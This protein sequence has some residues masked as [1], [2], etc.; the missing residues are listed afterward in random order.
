MLMKYKA[1]PEGGWGWVVT[2][3]AFLTYAIV[4][5]V[6]RAMSVLFDA[7]QR[8]F[9]ST[10]SATSWITSLMFGFLACGTLPG[11]VITG[12]LGPR[13][14]MMIG[15]VLSCIGTVVVSQSTNINT[16]YVGSVIA[17]TGF[18][19]AYCNATSQLGIYFDRKRSWAFGMASLGSP[20]CGMLLP[21]LMTI[22]AEVYGWSSA[23]LIVA[24]FCLNL[25]VGASLLRPVIIEGD[26]D[27]KIKD[28]GMNS[29]DVVRKWDAQSLTNCDDELNPVMFPEVDTFQFLKAMSRSASNIHAAEDVSSEQQVTHSLPHLN[30]PEVRNTR[31]TYKQAILNN[32]R[33]KQ[34]QNNNELTVKLNIDTSSGDDK[35]IPD[36]TCTKGSDLKR[37]TDVLEPYISLISQWRFMLYGLGGFLDFLVRF[38]PTWF[39][40]VHV[41][42]LGMTRE[43]GAYLLIV[44]SV[45][46]SVIRP[47]SGFATTFVS[48]NRLRRGFEMS[49]FATTQ[50]LMGI[51]N[52]LSTLATTFPMLA[53][54]MACFGMTNGLNAVYC[55]PI[56]TRLV[57]IERL[58]HAIGVFHFISGLG[59]LTGPPFAGYLADCSKSYSAVFYFCGV[60]S[61]MSGLV[62]GALYILVQKYG[63]RITPVHAGEEK[64]Q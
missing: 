40:V 11:S 30:R 21:L 44:F 57:P 35:S 43:Q 7:F 56:I 55:F 54:Y 27:R 24:G 47:I 53:V 61:L 3:T 52:L 51:L 33:A 59:I 28:D 8:E 62:V 39:I 18:G 4:W 50:I 45:F 20:A 2:F 12:V 34:E 37:M 42:S 10:N 22:I 15:G 23:V 38:T 60:G 1:P 49:A 17:G 25:C 32:F 29:P 13:K 5:A 46:D 9:H 6:P 36:V 16:A 31:S 58:H 63:V 19:F 14:T 41:Q 48:Q 64:T 26:E